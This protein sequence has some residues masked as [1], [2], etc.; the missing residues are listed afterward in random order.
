MEVKVVVESG[1]DKKRRFRRQVSIQEDTLDSR[2]DDE[3]LLSGIKYGDRFSIK[4]SPSRPIRSHYHPHRQQP[5]EPH[6]FKA[7]EPYKCSCLVKSNQVEVIELNGLPSNRRPPNEP[8][9]LY[10]ELDSPRRAVNQTLTE[11]HQSRHGRHGRKRQV[12]DFSSNP[13]LSKELAKKSDSCKLFLQIHTFQFKA[14]LDNEFSWTLV[15]CVLLVRLIIV[16]PP[17]NFNLLYVE[18][19]RL[20]L[21]HPY[22]GRNS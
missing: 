10:T 11:T 12:S 7:H 21:Y 18:F 8:N 19:R 15:V 16:G 6:E 2:D 1:Q 13:L 22:T 17:L 5:H 3:A 9:E 14:Q 4:Q 20:F